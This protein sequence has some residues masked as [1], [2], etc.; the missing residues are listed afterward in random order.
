MSGVKNGT[1]KKLE[2]G[3]PPHANAKPHA[4]LMKR[5]AKMT[6]HEIFLTA[7]KSG[8]YT[9]SGKLRKPYR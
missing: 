2:F 1:K 6:P 4:Q 3:L 8:I 5:L 9:K 7:V